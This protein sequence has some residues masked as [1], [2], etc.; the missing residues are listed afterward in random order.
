MSSR[1]L[2][3]LTPAYCPLPTAA[4]APDDTI[5]RT[6]SQSDLAVGAFKGQKLIS[7][8][9]LTRSHIDRIF[10]VADY[11]SHVV[12]TSGTCEVAKGC[13][14]ASVFYEP[15]TRTSSSFQAA[16]LRLGGQVVA[17]GDV[18]NSS[19]AKGETLE[20]TMRCLQCYVN[21]IV[22]RHPEVSARRECE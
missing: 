14:M 16:M 12:A 2:P 18:Q 15:S 3:P 8:L 13:V 1:P 10:D 7:V 11:M 17:I 20:D 5:L 22:M 6:S 4:T 9:P 21:I 19:V